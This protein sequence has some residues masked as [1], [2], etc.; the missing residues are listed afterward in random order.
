MLEAGVEIYEVRVDASALASEADEEPAPTTLHAKA[1]IADQEWLF[2]GS[3]NMDPRSIEINTEMGLAI[4]SPELATELRDS[5]MSDL[6]LF[7]YKVELDDKGNLKWI[8]HGPNGEEVFTKEP[9]ASFGRRF[10]SGFYEIL[11]EGQL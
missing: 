9:Q 7:A 11:P 3:L 2:V 8:G 1:L 6:E 10:S 4:E 5:V